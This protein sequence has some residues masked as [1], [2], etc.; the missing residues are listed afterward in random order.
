[1]MPGVA[2]AQEATVGRSQAVAVA[3]GEAAERRTVWLILA[4]ATIIAA[5]L[6]LPFL[7]H[8]SLWLDEIFTREIIRESSLSGLWNH[9]KA[10]EST[11]PLY[12]F[13][14]WLV[15]ARSTVTMRL[16]SALALTTAVPVGYLA[17]RRLVGWQA[18]LATAA[19]L[20]VSPMLVSYSTDARSYGL[21]VLM[22]LLSVWSFSILREDGSAR[23][24]GWWVAASVACVW[25]HYFGVFVVGSE[26]LVLLV[27][28]PGMRRATVCWTAL[29]GLCLIPLVPLVASQSGDERAEFIAGI[30]LKT[31][32]AETVR[33]FAM[34]PNV[35]RAWLEVLG[36]LVFCL[37]VAIGA[38]FAL[39]ARRE[40]RVL[41]ALS[42]IMCG[43]PLVLA[44]VGIEDR[45]YARNLIA[46]VP[47]VAALAAPAMLR[48]RAAPLAIYLVL[49]TAASVWVATDW[50]YEQADWKA[51]LSRAQ[52]IDPSAA[53][54]AVSRLGAPVVQTY[55]A[56]QP[57]ASGVLTRHAWII[58]EPVRMAGNRALGPAP[59][60]TLPGFAVQRTLEVQ[61]F[62]LILVAAKVPMRIAPTQ[63]VGATVFAGDP[64]SG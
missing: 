52:A 47:L 24:F 54:V 48:F 41:L 29:V 49:A 17:I 26:V 22:A 3:A 53:V 2:M 6:R 56:R 38:W 11:P 15:H 4:A 50:R 34:G 37:A 27:V 39:H 13:I 18:A 14:G 43:V 51:A 62:R 21:F 36:L 28:R 20:A 35:P 23:Q 16:I 5:G 45:F 63:V 33:Q 64:A 1:M 12:Y 25:T 57:A 59:A 31:R 7:D 32:V 30:P 40:L 61:G 60:T 10:T 46:A 55:L 42:L 58:V 8:Q 9:V 44:A 19:I